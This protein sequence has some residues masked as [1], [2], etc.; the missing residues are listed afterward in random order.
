MAWTM[1]TFSLD[2]FSDASLTLALFK[3][4]KNAMELKKKYLDRVALLDAGMWGVSRSSEQGLFAV[5]LAGKAPHVLGAGT[6]AYCRNHCSMWRQYS[7]LSRWPQRNDGSVSQHLCSYRECSKCP[8][9]VFIVPLSVT[10]THETACVVVAQHNGRTPYRARS[11]ST[12]F[13]GYRLF[14]S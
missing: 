5:V 1:Q 11:D 14:A 2:G 3:N 10:M 7:A 12:P 6:P 9:M 13:S 8:S 4:V